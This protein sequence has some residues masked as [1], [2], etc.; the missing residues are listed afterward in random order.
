MTADLQYF[1]GVLEINVQV[2]N[3]WD[4]NIYLVSSYNIYTVYADAGTS[5][6]IVLLPKYT[7]LRD[8]NQT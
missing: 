6:I 1:S 2:D 8:E 4:G 3:K 7:M 5:G